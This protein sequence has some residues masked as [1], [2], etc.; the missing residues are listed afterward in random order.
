[1]TD[2]KIINQ[3]RITHVRKDNSGDIILL[4]GDYIINGRHATYWISK[5]GPISMDKEQREDSLKHYVLD[6]HTNECIYIKLVND[7]DG[8]ELLITEHDG[9]RTNHLNELPTYE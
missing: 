6:E 5:E 1:M 9:I 4:V 2:K 3:C 8:N 7:K